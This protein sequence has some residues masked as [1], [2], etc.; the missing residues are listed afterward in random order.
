MFIW[1]R[2]HGTVK[3]KIW[4]TAQG[5]VHRVEYLGGHPLLAESALE[6]VRNWKYAPASQASETSWRS[7]SDLTERSPAGY[8]G[9][10]GPAAL[11]FRILA[12]QLSSS[13]LTSTPNSAIG[14]ALPQQGASL[15]HHR[16]VRV[17]FAANV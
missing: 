3:L 15:R 9:Y 16:A 12:S 7:S 4:I 10:F 1:P 5:A 2:V 8:V 14:L 17:S 11:R 6:A 13:L